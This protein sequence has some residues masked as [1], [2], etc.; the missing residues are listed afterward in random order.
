MIRLLLLSNMGPSAKKP[1]SGRFVYNQFKALQKEKNLEVE[2]FYLTQDEV[3]RIKRLLRYPLFYIHFLAKFLFAKKVDI[4]HVHF[5]FPNILL[6]I[7]YKAL[8]N[9]K[10]KLIATFHGSDVYAYQPPSALYKWAFTKLDHAI[11]V[12]KNL[13]ERFKSY[14]DVS[15]ASTSLLS[16]GILDVYQP[17]TN[18]TYEYDFIFVGHQNYNKGIDRL[19]KIAKKGAKIAVVGEGATSQWAS[20]NG[21]IRVD[22][23]GVL[24]PEQLVKLYCS[25]RFLLS[26]SRNESFGLVMTEAMASGTPVIATETDGSRAQVIDGQNGLLLQND[27]EWLDSKGYESLYQALKMSMNDYQLMQKEALNSVSQHSLTYIVNN[28]LTIYQKLI[29]TRH[30]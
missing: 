11:F 9:S 4:I 25:S 26:L 22:F 6:A 10:V 16:A 20:Q 28:L 13:F 7:T 17:P 14:V 27:D 12:S 19:Q 5:F 2:Y 15:E 1:N 18:Q 3:G 23:Y 30:H 29:L 8:I 21:N 24:A